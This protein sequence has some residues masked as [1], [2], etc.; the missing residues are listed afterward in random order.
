MRHALV[1]ALWL[2]ARF[3]LR[4]SAVWATVFAVAVWVPLQVRFVIFAFRLL[5][6]T[7]GR[8]GGG[9]QD[10]REDR[11]WQQ[12]VPATTMDT[13]HY[14]GNLVVC[15]RA[16]FSLRAV[17]A[18]ETARR[19]DLLETR[20]QANP[21][22]QQEHKKDDPGVCSISIFPTV[23]LGS[24]LIHCR[25]P[26]WMTRPTPMLKSTVKPPNRS[27]AHHGS[28]ARCTSL[29]RAMAPPTKPAP[30]TNPPTPP[31]K[32]ITRRRFSPESSGQGQGAGHSGCSLC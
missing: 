9:Q 10:G 13:G 21:H 8:N 28:F 7:G 20:S 17:R 2:A 26:T 25:R 18:A 16:C 27:H 12:G 23:R 30:T 22:Q 29:A 32:V 19:N 31:M 6:R 3:L 15:K 1:V 4:Y 14:P 11:S 5:R 24:F